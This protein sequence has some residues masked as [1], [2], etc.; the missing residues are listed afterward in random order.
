MGR[1]KPVIKAQVIPNVKN[2]S[3]NIDDI[4]KEP[5]L[6]PSHTNDNTSSTTPPTVVSV[7]TQKVQKNQKISDGQEVKK[8]SNLD[9]KNPNMVIPAPEGSTVTSAPKPNVK[10]K[11]KRKSKNSKN[12]DTSQSDANDN[13]GESKPKRTRKAKDPNAPKRPPNAYL[14][15]TFAKRAELKQQNPK[16][17]PKEITIMLGEAWRKLSETEKKPYYDLVTQALAQWQEDTKAYQAL[18]NVGLTRDTAQASEIYSSSVQDNIQQNSL[19]TQL[20]PDNNLPEIGSSNN[21][22]D[23]LYQLQANTT[24]STCVPYNDYNSYGQQQQGSMEAL[25]DMPPDNSQTYGY[26]SDMNGTHLYTDDNINTSFSL[27]TMIPIKVNIVDQD[28]HGSYF[29]QDFHTTQE[30]QEQ[31]QVVKQDLLLCQPFDP[32]GT[33]QRPESNTISVDEN[34]VIQKQEKPDTNNMLLCQPFEP[35]KMSNVVPDNDKIDHTWLQD[36]DQHQQT[37]V[38]YSESIIYARFTS[39]EM[40]ERGSHLIHQGTSQEIPQRVEMYQHQVQQSLQSLNRHN[41]EP[42]NEMNQSAHSIQY[43]THGDARTSD[44]SFDSKEEAINLVSKGSISEITSEISPFSAKIISSDTKTTKTLQTITHEEAFSHIISYLLDTIL[45]SKDQIKYIVHR[46]VHG[47]AE[48]QAFILRSDPSPTRALSELD[49]LSELAP[50]H[51]HASVLIIKSCLKELPNSTNYVFFDTLFHQSI[52]PHVYT[53]ALPFEEAKQKR[54]RKYGFHGISHSYVTKIAANYLGIDWNDDDTKFISLH[55]G[56]GAS[57][58][59]VKGGKSVNTTMGLT[60]LEGLP[61]ATRSGSIDPSAI[62][63]LSSKARKCEESHHSVEKQFHLTEAESILNHDSGFKGLCGLSNFGD[64]T[65]SI[66]EGN[67]NHERAKLTFD[68]FVNRIVNYIGSYF[69]ELEG[70]ISALVFTGGIGENSKELRE[71]VTEK[72]ECL[73]FPK[74]D[75]EKNEKVEGSFKKGDDVVDISNGTEGKSRVLVVETNEEKEMVNQLIT[76]I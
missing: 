31:H 21:T 16:M 47:A 14:Q 48:T 63:H 64:I 59:A 4:S 39:H 76:K 52:P 72:V 57:V 11:R 40:T 65:K 30:Q 10:P 1:F 45:K 24:N 25:L 55:L 53:Y 46:V 27:P 37:Q 68:I 41:P 35:S 7:S 62:F 43:L 51:N 9:E 60:P 26:H 56:S 15:F 5:P 50:L 28:T 58:C 33:N 49:S 42:I 2:T 71:S 8:A 23:G 73:G 34:P 19:N 74:V 22:T 75:K 67:E 70:N 38:E 13:E 29:T 66:H 20:I 32:T 3:S 44:I 18:N 69:V 61:G 54:I 12:N 6:T 17:S 36:E